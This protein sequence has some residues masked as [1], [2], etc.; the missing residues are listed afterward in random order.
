MVI[1]E[2]G[3]HKLHVMNPLGVFSKAVSSE[4]FSIDKNAVYF[5][6]TMP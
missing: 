2:A 4:R 5:V 1:A 6:L 3:R